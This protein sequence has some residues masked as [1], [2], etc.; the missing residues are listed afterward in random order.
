MMARA[1]QKFFLDE[2]DIP[3]KKREGRRKKGKKGERLDSVL[4]KDF[5]LLFVVCVSRD[6]TEMYH[7]LTF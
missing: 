4:R 2:H 1:G 7:A 6:M 3:C 5:S